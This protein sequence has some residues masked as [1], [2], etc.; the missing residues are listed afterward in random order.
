VLYGMLKN[1]TPYDESKHRQQ[2]GLPQPEQ[3]AGSAAGVSTDLIDIADAVHEPN[4]ID[5]DGLATL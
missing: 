1:M 4:E 3:A 5:I 2:L